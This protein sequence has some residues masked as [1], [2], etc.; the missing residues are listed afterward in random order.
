MWRHVTMSRIAGTERVNV[1][2]FNVKRSE[3]SVDHSGGFELTQ[4]DIVSWNDI[5]PGPSAG[6][7]IVSTRGGVELGKATA[8]LVEMVFLVGEGGFEPGAQAEAEE[9]Q[10]RRA[11]SEATE[12]EAF[13]TGGAIGEPGLQVLKVLKCVGGI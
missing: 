7:E 8:G 4:A 1:M 6:S 9:G 5:I 12:V 11:H 13:G 10:G 2:T 3:G